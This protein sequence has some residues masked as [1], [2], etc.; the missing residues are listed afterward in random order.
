MKNRIKTI[1]IILTLLLTS[2]VLTAATEDWKLIL[3]KKGIKV[4]TR[5]AKGCPLD[6]F[7]GIAVI[8][9]PLETC[10]RVLRDANNQ[11]NWMGDCLKS[12]ILKKISNNHFIVYNVLHAT[13]PLSNRDLQID[14]IFIDDFT[15]GIVTVRMKAYKEPIQ[16]VSKKYVR[17]TDMKATCI[18]KRIEKN[19]TKVTYINRVNPMAPVPS[20]IANM[21]V[22]KNPYK[23]LLG[24]RK[25]AQL[26]N[27][28]N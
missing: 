3:N 27:Y 4:Y 21:I 14:T 20:G 11:A 28:Q 1:F 26:P 18:M 19:K 15:N 9:A 6:Q 23:T 7:M 5:P 25:M 2:A 10:A 8:D 17:I 12:K 16:P 13:W 22:K 24:L